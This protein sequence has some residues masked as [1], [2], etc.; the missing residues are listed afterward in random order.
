MWC[1]CVVLLRLRS[2]PHG[3]QKC[4]RNSH[5]FWLTDVP[6]GLSG[7]TTLHTNTL[8]TFSLLSCSGLGGPPIRASPSPRSNDTWNMGISTYCK[9]WRQQKHARK[10]L[11]VYHVQVVFNALSFR[12][13]CCVRFFTTSMN[14]KTFLCNT[15]INAPLIGQSAVVCCVGEL[16]EKSRVLASLARLER[17]SKNS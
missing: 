15:Q 12:L 10:Q 9:A 1:I 3:Y 13:L 14:S 7:S 16:M 2:A 17:H 5:R 6:N 11:Q 8:M 4:T